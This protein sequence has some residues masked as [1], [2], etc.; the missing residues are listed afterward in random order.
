MRLIDADDLKDWSE[1]VQLTDDGGID[2]ND[3]EE[4]LESM[5][6]I[7]AIFCGKGRMITFTERLNLA[8][9]F[10]EWAERYHVSKEPLSVITWMIFEKHFRPSGR[11]QFHCETRDL[12]LSKEESEHEQTTD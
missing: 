8:K 12:R 5:P 9:E 10:D 2:I 11:A 1:N 7:D 4:K 3:F 6:T